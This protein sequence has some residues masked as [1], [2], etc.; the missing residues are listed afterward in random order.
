MANHSLVSHKFCSKMGTRAPKNGPS[1]SLQIPI[2]T[3]IGSIQ[4]SQLFVV[5]Y[6]RTRVKY[7]IKKLKC[8]Q[9]SVG[10]QLLIGTIKIV[11][12]VPRLLYD[13]YRKLTY[14]DI[15]MTND[16]YHH[17]KHKLT[18]LHNYCHRSTTI[19]TNKKYKWK[20]TSVKIVYLV[21]VILLNCVQLLCN[22]SKI[23]HF[24]KHFYRNLLF[25]R[26]IKILKKLPK[27]S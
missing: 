4:F 15:I 24:F 21:I 27:N 5:I 22:F 6:V 12:R 26:N 16:S 9:K 13:I 20:C 14:T 18:A 25:F 10:G 1:C 2:I 8:G 17:H 7:L 3:Q 23:L 19:V 11:Q